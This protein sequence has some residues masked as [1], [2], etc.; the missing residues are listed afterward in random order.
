MLSGGKLLKEMLNHSIYSGS[1]SYT[2][3]DFNKV[4]LWV[5]W[6]S[7]ELQKCNVKMGKTVLIFETPRH[8]HKR[9][10]FHDIILMIKI[11]PKVIKIKK[12]PSVKDHN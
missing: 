7:L 5:L 1:K 2:E 9:K 8:K 12:N 4:F 10:R 6:K 3:M 11:T